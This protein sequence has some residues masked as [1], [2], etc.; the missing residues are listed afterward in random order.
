MGQRSRWQ[1]C[2]RC[3]AGAARTP[4]DTGITATDLDVAAGG[5]AGSFKQL[6]LLLR[7][8]GGGVGEFHSVGGHACGQALG[9]GEGVEGC[10]LQSQGWESNGKEV[11]DCG[12]RRFA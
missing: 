4:N 1:T 8:S 6:L 7:L 9:G 10:G 3:T 11:S 2:I 12:T 5:V